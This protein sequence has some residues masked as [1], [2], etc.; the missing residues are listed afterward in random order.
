MRNNVGV[1]GVRRQLHPTHPP[2][3]QTRADLSIQIGDR[4]APSAQL[5]HS[6][7]AQLAECRPGPAIV[8]AVLILG[9][10]RPEQKTHFVPFWALPN[11]AQNVSLVPFGERWA[12]TSQAPHS[13]VLLIRGAAQRAESRAH[14]EV[15]GRCRPLL[16]RRHDAPAPSR[17]CVCGCKS[18]TPE[19]RSIKERSCQKRENATVGLPAAL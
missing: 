11:E 1:G 2:R 4:C 16:C 18:P 9:R 6:A 15:P 19:V 12:G 14:R 17:S 5:R 7:P 13:S 10:T 8:K 3:R